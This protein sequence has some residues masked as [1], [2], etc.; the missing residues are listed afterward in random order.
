MIQQLVQAGKQLLTGQT[1]TTTGQAPVN[2][3]S[4]PVGT[5]I[6]VA[7]Q[8]PTNNTVNSQAGQVNAQSP[9]NI[10]PTIAEKLLEKL[11]DKL[12]KAGYDKLPAN[13]NVQ[14]LLTL[15]G[16]I[17]TD[18]QNKI[19]ESASN[20]AKRPLMAAASVTGALNQILREDAKEENNI[21]DGVLNTLKT[22]LSLPTQTE[23]DSKLKENT[24][25]MV[26]RLAT[27]GSWWDKDLKKATKDIGP[28]AIAVLT[29]NLNNQN[30]QQTLISILDSYR[31][32]DEGYS[33]KAID[34]AAIDALLEKA[35]AKAP[36]LAKKILHRFESKLTKTY[37]SDTILNNAV[38][39]SLTRL[40]DMITKHAPNVL[41]AP[42]DQA[43]A[44]SVAAKIDSLIQR[45]Q[46]VKSA[47]ANTATTATV[48]AAPAQ[49]VTVN[50][51]Q[52][53]PVYSTPQAVT[54][55]PAVQQQVVPAQAALVPAPTA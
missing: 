44:Q 28:K 55:N 6:N 22:I 35:F 30:I 4:A 12:E 38:R 15:K 54:V 45:N 32:F 29:E 9:A 51:A 24:L 2:I 18:V 20:E 27:Q 3:T 11:N 21:V 49:T 42:E 13:T 5:T 37:E 17:A 25:D 7:G 1:T 47:T 53:A 10:D 19:F 16:P 26:A 48:Q 8:A 36:E 41:K 23:A 43:L 39:Q 14:E 46:P 52:Q 33:D 31:P 50:N 34:R 40:K